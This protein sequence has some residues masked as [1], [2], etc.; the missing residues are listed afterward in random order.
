MEDKGTIYTIGYASFEL[1]RFIKEI[2]KHGIQCVV[3]V[4]SIPASSHFPDYNHEQ[5]EKKLLSQ[6]IYYRHYPEFGA[7]QED[8]QWYTKEGYLDFEKYTSSDY[9][10]K[11]M[12]KIQDSMKLG[13]S[14]VFMC[15]EKDPLD[16][17]RAIMVSKAFHDD[18]YS[19]KHIEVNKKGE[20]YLEDHEDLEKRMMRKFGDDP[21]QLSIVETMKMRIEN[22]Y[23]KQNAIIGYRKE[24]VE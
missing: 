19:I 4:R 11:G 22:A 18:G 6:G 24:K 17:H 5:F 8:N 2:K 23:K 10:K 21:N 3:D 20:E 16:C 13:Y 7:R 1:P 12:T 14:F 15:A 9:F